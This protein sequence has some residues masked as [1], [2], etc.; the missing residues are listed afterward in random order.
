[1]THQGIRAAPAKES[2]RPRS[3][4]SGKFSAS[5]GQTPAYGRQLCAHLN[6]GRVPQHGIAV[7]LDQRPPQSPLCA[8]L[9]CFSDTDPDRLDWSLC[10]G[11]DVHVANAGV[12]D[13]G[14]LAR[15]IE[16]LKAVRPSRLQVHR[17]DAPTEFVIIGGGA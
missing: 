5:A 9:A 6:A 13:P 14:R 16:A 17:A 3:A 8:P 12:C 1:M 10:S 4:H 11:R 7:F 2:A 15:L